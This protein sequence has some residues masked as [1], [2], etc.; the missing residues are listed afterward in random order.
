MEQEKVDFLDGLAY[1]ELLGA[2]TKRYKEEELMVSRKGDPM[3]MLKWSVTDRAGNT[4]KISDYITSAM[5]FKIQNLCN[6]LKIPSFYDEVSGKFDV[7]AF[8][9]Q[10]CCAVI[11]K[12]ENDQYGSKIEKYIPI[13]YT[14]MVNSGKDF[15]ASTEKSERTQSRVENVKREIKS[16]AKKQGFSGFDDGLDE[17]D[18]PF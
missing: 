15:V 8:S 18:Y 11:K 16:E 10:N 6:V 4:G 9:G 1:C 17:D 13:A 2:Y 5:R 3:M 14:E 7:R 12:D